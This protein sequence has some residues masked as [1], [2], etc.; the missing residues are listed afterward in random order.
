MSS[1]YLL[2]AGAAAMSLPIIIHLLNRRRHRVID[3]AAMEFLF[4][5]KKKLRYRVVLE[6]MLLPDSLFT[7]A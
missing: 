1:V 3:W 7:K 2:A 5:A 4:Q 6:E